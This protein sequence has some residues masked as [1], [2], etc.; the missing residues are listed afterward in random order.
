VLDVPLLIES[1][2]NKRCDRILFVD[3]DEEL[4]LKRAMARG[5]TTN[6]FRDREAAQLPLDQKRQIATDTIDNNGPIASLDQR[7]DEFINTL[8]NP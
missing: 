6:Q 4:R 8:T 5:W 7:I 1:G 3:T 2:W